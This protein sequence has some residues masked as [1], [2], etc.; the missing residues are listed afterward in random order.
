VSRTV[1]FGKVDPFNNSSKY[2]ENELRHR[3]HRKSQ[4][5]TEAHPGMQRVHLYLRDQMR[6]QLA[7]ENP[8]DF[9]VRDPAW[10]MENVNSFGELDGVSVLHHDGGYTQKEATKGFLIL[11][12]TVA[13]TEV[14]DLASGEFITLEPTQML[15][16][17][18]QEFM[19]RTPY[20][21]PEAA[22]S[23]WFAKSLIYAEDPLYKILEGIADCGSSAPCK[24]GTCG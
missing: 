12:A 8:S 16:I 13:P 23:R 7:G 17:D 9:T 2:L 14:F 3:H 10:H 22:S 19:H 21:S 4:F 1:D 24:F 6:L 5:F 11:W 20:L 15:A 18:N